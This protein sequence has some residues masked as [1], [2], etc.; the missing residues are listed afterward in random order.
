MQRLGQDMFNPMAPYQSQ[1][2]AAA[3]P[4][5]LP[6]HFSGSHHATSSLL[7]TGHSFHGPYYHGM[8][9]L[10]PTKP[11]KAYDRLLKHTS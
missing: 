5:Q 1:P 10:V 11:G 4:P 6:A 2:S 9:R 7:L 8:Q 3:L